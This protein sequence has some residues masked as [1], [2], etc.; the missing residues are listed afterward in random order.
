LRRE[1]VLHFFL[2]SDILNSEK[3]AEVPSAKRQID[4]GSNQV[5]WATHHSEENQGEESSGRG[6]DRF[7]H[8]GGR[9]G[10]YYSE[11]P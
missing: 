3:N 6:A 7:D 4:H 11:T 1:R 8:S 9:F 5:P 2:N 10:H